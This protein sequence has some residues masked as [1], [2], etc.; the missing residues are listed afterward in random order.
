MR[1]ASVSWLLKLCLVAWCFF[2]VCGSLYSDCDNKCRMRNYFYDVGILTGVFLQY[3]DC[4]ECKTSRCVNREMT[5]TTCSLIDGAGQF[6]KN[7]STIAYCT[8]LGTDIVEA[9]P[10]TAT[11]DWFPYGERSQC[12]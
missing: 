12:K 11:G 2:L 7:G 4:V 6:A 5:S 9:A 3:S 1:S 8:G 10:F